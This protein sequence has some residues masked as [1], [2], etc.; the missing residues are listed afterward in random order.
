MTQEQRKGLKVCDSSMRLESHGGPVTKGMM[1]TATSNEKE[2][3]NPRR[4]VLVPPKKNPSASVK[5]FFAPSLRI[6]R[7]ILPSSIGR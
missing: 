4:G 3:I 6:T 5:H 7:I 2:S 1:L